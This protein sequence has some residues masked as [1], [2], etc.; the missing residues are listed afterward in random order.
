MAT[1][2]LPRIDPKTGLP[3]TTSNPQ[4]VARLQGI[5]TR[6]AQQQAARRTG[7]APTYSGPLYQQM[8]ASPGP[9]SSLAA[10]TPTGSGILGRLSAELAAGSPSAASVGTG[11]AALPIGAQSTSNAAGTFP[12]ASG[13]TYPTEKTLTGAAADFSNVYLPDV[14]ANPDVITAR[15]LQNRGIDPFGTGTGLMQAMSPYMD[16]VRAL[17]PLAWGGNMPPSTS[18]P[19]NWMDQRAKMGITPGGPA[20]DFRTV[21]DTL[22]GLGRNSDTYQM[23]YGEGM[24][25]EDQV[26]ATKQMVY[27]AAQLGLPP[28]FQ[29]SVQNQMN[30]AALKFYLD[31]YQ[32]G[33]PR[34]FGSFV[35]NFYG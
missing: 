33:Q 11:S 22:G 2:T 16:A 27:A 34:N 24:S 28:E 19:I 20:F 6:Y 31:Q 13:S 8:S 5:T 18:S 1:R 25:P 17:L 29:R 7:T 21:M 30:A 23:L 26:N 15:M 3:L 12:T 32:G 14:L 9:S 35:P 4:S 10:G